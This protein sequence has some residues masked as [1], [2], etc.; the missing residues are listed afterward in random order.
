LKEK[1]KQQPSRISWGAVRQYWI[2]FDERFIA[3]SQHWTEQVIE[4][5]FIKFKDPKGR[6]ETILPRNDNSSR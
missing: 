5:E 6:Q 2:E 3:E 4:K 1:N